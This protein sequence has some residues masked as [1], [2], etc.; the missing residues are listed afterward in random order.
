MVFAGLAWLTLA[1]LSQVLLCQGIKYS[2][3]GSRLSA[4]NYRAKPAPS[5]S[6][7][8]PLHTILRTSS[9]NH[10]PRGSLVR[11]AQWSESHLEGQLEGISSESTDQYQPLDADT[12]RDLDRES[13]SLSGPSDNM[14]GQQPVPIAPLVPA[15]IGPSILY[16]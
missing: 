14:Q 2:K 5:S 1:M 4:S 9:V 3:T 11:A 16:M 12:V 10:Q 7:R 15:V 13:W 8:E 6:Q